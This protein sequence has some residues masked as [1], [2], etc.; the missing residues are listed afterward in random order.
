MNLRP[1]CHYA[2][3]RFPNFQHGFQA[4]LRNSILSYLPQ[5]MYCDWQP[6]QT[7]RVVT[8]SCKSFKL[9]WV[10]YYGRTQ[11]DYYL[12]FLLVL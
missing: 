5:A 7:D 8:N 2:F 11:S 10:Y 1:I 9:A 3:A 6:K 12:Y 4:V